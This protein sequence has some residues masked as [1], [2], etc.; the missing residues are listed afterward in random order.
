MFASIC[1][2]PFVLVRVQNLSQTKWLLEHFW[3]WNYSLCTLLHCLSTKELPNKR[4][5]VAARPLSACIRMECLQVGRLDS[6]DSGSGRCCSS[7]GRESGRSG[8]GWGAGRHSSPSPSG[9]GV[10]V[11]RMQHKLYDTAPA[12]RA[13]VNSQL[14]SQNTPSPGFGPTPQPPRPGPPFSWINPICF[15]PGLLKTYRKNKKHSLQIH[16]QNHPCSN[17][18]QVNNNRS[19]KGLMLA[20]HHLLSDGYCGQMTEQ[21]RLVSKWVVQQQQLL[22]RECETGWMY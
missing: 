12:R 14:K 20:F 16:R 21:Q 2:S 8:P 15:P 3:V 10:K 22:K 19:H 11:R 18:N 9:R 17:F 6:L 13:E 1:G 5:L 7:P 4:Q